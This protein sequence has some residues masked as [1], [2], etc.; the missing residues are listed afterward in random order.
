MD[1]TDTSSPPSVTFPPREYGYAAV[2]VNYCLYQVTIDA[3]CSYILIVSNNPDTLP[4][5]APRR[6]RLPRPGIAPGGAARPC[7]AG[8]S[9]AGPTWCR[10]SRRDGPVQPGSSGGG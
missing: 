4:P 3:L 8:A 2:S 1:R 10:C 7:G 6:L 5:P 9:A